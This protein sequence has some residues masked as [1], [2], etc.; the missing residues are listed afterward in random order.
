MKYLTLKTIKKKVFK[1]LFKFFLSCAL[2]G[3]LIMNHIH[4]VNLIP[5]IQKTEN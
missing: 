3:L 5:K 4:G 2:I 1:I